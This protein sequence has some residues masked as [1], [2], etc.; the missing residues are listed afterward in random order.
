[1][2]PLICTAKEVGAGFDS[3][4]SEEDRQKEAAKKS[5]RDCGGASHMRLLSVSPSHS[6]SL[7]LHSFS[8]CL[9]RFSSS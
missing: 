8:V 7:G 6:Y 5:D 1:M 9:A 4:S 2:V 3:E